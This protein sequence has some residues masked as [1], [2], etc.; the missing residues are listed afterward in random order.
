MEDFHLRNPA[1]EGWQ[2]PGS[3]GVEWVVVCALACLHEL[4][5]LTQMFHPI[6]AILAPGPS[7]SHP[8]TPML[9]EK[10]T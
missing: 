4:I 8:C 1:T 3:L 7:L 9:G 10:R 2:T 5:S 6:K